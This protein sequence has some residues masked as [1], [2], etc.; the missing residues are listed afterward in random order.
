MFHFKKIEENKTAGKR[1]YDAKK[2]HA[3]LLEL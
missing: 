3:K 2:G 1:K